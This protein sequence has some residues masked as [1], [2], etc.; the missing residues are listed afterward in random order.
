M[1][2]N[3]VSVN[4]T[5]EEHINY[6]AV[7]NRIANAD[8]NKATNVLTFYDEEG[9]QKF[10]V[11]IEQDKLEL[12]NTLAKT[13]YAADAKAVGDEIDRVENAI[14]NI[15]STLSV[16]GDAA[17]AGATGALIVNAMNQVAEGFND[18]IEDYYEAHSDGQMW[19][20]SNNG[21]HVS[22]VTPDADEE[23]QTYV[24]DWLDDHPEAT[25]TVEDG[26][27]TVGKLHPSLKK[28]VSRVVDTFE[29]LYDTTEDEVT[30]LEDNSYY[31]S[32]QTVTFMKWEYGLTSALSF[33]QRANGDWMVPKPSRNPESSDVPTQAIGDVVASYINH[34][35]ITY[36]GAGAFCDTCNSEM[37]CSI[38]AQ[39]VIQGITYENSKYNG[40]TTNKFGDYIGNNI[41][42]NK[43]SLMSPRRTSGYITNELAMW[44]AEQN[45]LYYIDYT[46][47]HP[48]SQLQVGDL[49]FES[50]PNGESI[51]LE[52]ARTCYL[53]IHHVAIVL[54][55]YPEDDRIVVAQAGGFTGT[56]QEYTQPQ[57][58]SNRRDN[59]KI[60][61]LKVGEHPELL[62]VYARPRYGIGTSTPR[63]VISQLFFNP[64][65]TIS[66]SDNIKQLGQAF[67]Q[68]PM[69]PHK[70]YT[71]VL[72]G[73][74]PQY[75][76]EKSSFGVEVYTPSGNQYMAIARYNNCGDEIAIPFV[77]ISTI[78]D[79]TALRFRAYYSSSETDVSSNSYY[80]DAVGLYDG[81]CQSARPCIEKVDAADIIT[82]ETGVNCTE[83][84]YWKVDGRL[85]VWMKIALSA[86][87]TSNGQKKIATLSLG[88]I[89]VQVNTKRFPCYYNG[90]AR[91]L[92]LE[93]DGSLS[94]YYKN[95]EGTS[96]SCYIDV[97]I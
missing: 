72:K 4:N 21:V 77:P 39:L 74:L 24:E 82:V 14:P 80:L 62:P 31:G 92:V 76:A 23:I 95:G 45:R 32:G 90:E 55:V 70:M 64:S 11:E 97:L 54:A 18:A 66:S 84:Y 52:S 58:L 3:G 65:Q 67:L 13:G 33:L 10:N 17:D 59:I 37:D 47:D 81:L 38:L 93:S 1:A 29:D 40:N 12:D 7:E 16:N 26:S 15:D 41:P 8:Y 56:L 35:E 96:Y 86:N 2:I 57:G 20:D 53:Y 30:V 88:S 83:S 6:D 22:A 5:N 94:V 69:E 48:C 42:K 46:K 89:P 28:E 25:T 36:G 61:T 91:S 68:F 9:T 79:A 49:L 43:A 78:G 51:S 19:V 63:S 50:D 75:S 87:V 27:I 73:K 44:F 71:L 60:S 85:R 34:P